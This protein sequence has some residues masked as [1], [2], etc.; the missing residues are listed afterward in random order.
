[1]ITFKRVKSFRYMKGKGYFF[2]ASGGEKRRMRQ[3]I[4]E[5][6]SVFIQQKTNNEYD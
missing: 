4:K 3:V 1:M 5:L 2:F 6:E